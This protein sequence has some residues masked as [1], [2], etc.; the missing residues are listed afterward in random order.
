MRPGSKDK[1]H[2]ILITG[3]E[4][5]ELQKYTWAMSEAYGLDTKIA[6][7]KGKRPIGFWPWDIDCLEAVVDD[8][9]KDYPDQN[10]AECNAMKNLIARIDDLVKEAY[11]K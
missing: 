11:G 3:Q 1:K 9:L 10:S 8:V 2:Y 4:L 6:N 7:Y 5:I